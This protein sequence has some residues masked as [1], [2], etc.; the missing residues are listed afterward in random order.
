[1]S[2]Y[3]KNKLFEYSQPPSGRDVEKVL[4]VFYGFTGDAAEN[5]ATKIYCSFQASHPWFLADI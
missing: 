1:M 3:E 5:T 2:L 4:C